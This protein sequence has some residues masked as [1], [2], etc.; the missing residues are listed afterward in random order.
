MSIRQ[1]I[2]GAGIAETSTGDNELFSEEELNDEA[3]ENMVGGSFRMPKSGLVTAAAQQ[4]EEDYDMD[5]ELEHLAKS[6]EALRR[7]LDSICVVA[8]PA[9]TSP[10]LSSASL[11]DE[12]IDEGGNEDDHDS[13]EEDAAD[14]SSIK[15]EETVDHNDRRNDKDNTM[16]FSFILPVGDSIDTLSD[17]EEE[18]KIDASKE[19]TLHHEPEATT[20]HQQHGQVEPWSNDWLTG[21]RDILRS[22][23]S[24]HRV[25]VAEL[26]S[27]LGEFKREM[28]A[29]PP[30]AQDHDNKEEAVT[31]A[32]KSET[33][34]SSSGIDAFS[35]EEEAQNCV[36]SE[37]AQADDGIFEPMKDTFS[38]MFICNIK[39][40]GFA[41]SLF[42]FALQVTI[43]VLIGVNILKN[44]PDGN[45]L[46][47]PVGTSLD[48]VWAQVLALLVS[49][50]TQSDFMA[51]FDLINFKYDDI[52]LSLFEGA[53]HT[54][55]I[56]S[57]IC[58]FTI[59]VLSI[60]ISFILIVQSTT[61]IELFFNFAAV[62][63]VSELDNIAF[64]L[65]YKGYMA[66]GDLEQATRKLINQ[67]Q[68]WQRNMVAF[69]RIKRRIPVKWLRISIF[70][71][72]AVI[73][74]SFWFVVRYKQATGQYLHSICQ[75][76]DVNF[77]DKVSN[78][79]TA[80][81]CFFYNVTDPNNVREL[82]YGPFSGIY[83]VYHDN[84]DNFVW[85]GGRPV[86]YTRNIE[87]GD[88]SH[89]G[90]FSY[91]KNEKAWVFTIDGVRKA[92]SDKCN[93]LLRSPKTEAY[94]LG[95]V[96]TTGWSIW[97]DD[98][99]VPADP[100]FELSC[101]ECESDVDCSYL[102]GS[103]EKKI[104]VCD[105]SWT[106]RN[107]QT[108]FYCSTLHSELSFSNGGVTKTSPNDSKAFLH[109][110]GVAYKER[111]VYYSYMV[112]MPIE[113][114]FYSDGRFNV[115]EWEGFAIN[116]SLGVQDNDLAKLRDYFD[117]VHSVVVDINKV[118]FYVDGYLDVKNTLTFVSELTTAMEPHSGNVKW[119]DDWP[120]NGTTLH[121]SCLSSYLQS[122]CQ[123]FE[124]H[125]DETLWNQ[126]TEDSCTFYN[127]TD[128]TSAALLSYGHFSDIYEVSHDSHGSFEWK[129]RRPIYYQR[130]IEFGEGSHTGKFSYCESEEAWVFTIDT[131]M[132]VESDECNWLLRSP[133]TEAYSL[134]DAPRTGWSTIG[135]NHTLVPADRLFQF[136]C[137]ECQL[138]HNCTVSSG[139]RG[140]PVDVNGIDFS[141]AIGSYLNS[142]NITYGS[143]ISC[144]DVGKVTDM[145]YA[146]MSLTT[147][148][149]PLCWDV[150]RV[151]HMGHMFDVANAFNQN[152]SSWD[153]SSVTSMEGMFAS[154]S[155]FN[156]D[157]S[158]WD[159]SSV[160]VMGYMF[161]TA[162]SF[163]QDLSS[164]NVSNVITMELMFASA[165]A[166][167]QDI[168]SWDVSSVKSMGFMFQFNIAFNQDIA[169]WDVSCVLSMNDM[170]N[171]AS[172]FNQ[173]LCDWAVKTPSLMQVSHMFESTTCPNS[174][175]P[176][177][178]VSPGGTSA[179]P[180]PGPF[181][182]DCAMTECKH[183]HNCT[184]SS[185]N[186][187]VPVNVNGVDFMNV[188][189]SYLNS[190][191]STYGTKISCWDVGKVTDMSFAFAELNDF[192]E[193]LCWGVSSVISMVGMFNEAEA[194]NQDISSWGV[195]SVIN[196]QG[197][198]ATAI[199][200]NQ[201]IS[202][203]DVSRVTDM[204]GMFNEAEAFN[205]DISSW[206]VSSITNME[207]MFNHASTFNQDISS[208]D[209]STVTSMIYMFDNAS[210]FNQDVSSWDVSSVTDMNGMFALATVFNQDLSSWNVSSV[211]DMYFMFYQATAFNQ[212]LCNWA[213]KTPFLSNATRMF[214]LTRC[215]NSAT[216]QFVSPGG[217][218]DIP[219]LGP[220]CHEC[221]VRR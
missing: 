62:Q 221:I 43:L 73:L 139:N 59:G 113:I 79:C 209:V 106:G 160:K 164:W 190:G 56:V 38:L 200:F 129:G 60:G 125:F 133:K 5:D 183:R 177:Q 185:G 123:S 17:D 170:F 12:E 25:Q 93:W 58:R 207:W 66:I 188:I 148:N 41:Y 91:C 4:E 31:G 34:V 26:T 143:K 128:S 72:H 49:L 163:N 138:R 97:T 214:E 96:P 103:C 124:A 176:P 47:V 51:T 136:T 155:A 156:Q 7:E 90:K 180:H 107:C 173:N 16:D 13:I 202:S 55:W 120:A 111:P 147:F 74:Y 3:F 19:N 109:L 212:D 110:K 122:V 137:G 81:S 40:L 174:A 23:F 64:Q 181:C 198:F 14:D 220:F 193:P 182:H 104:C 216:P 86:Y 168:S 175:T 112:N 10:R 92:F 130:N 46:N 153:V 206:D 140:V 52:V 166:F 196:M 45:P 219:H 208:W 63:F 217:T 68:F 161:D 192:N 84:H 115:I 101:A 126:C 89:P 29:A 134:G 35:N 21:N 42:F 48:V 218:P 204:K 151:T 213:V 210:A 118:A 37:N 82:P 9:V 114:L 135:L 6:G 158:S 167:N 33:H 201:N 87:I 146:F 70:S 131:V 15:E 2:T 88:G 199:A 85:K 144:W 71:L 18:A 191:K 108:S 54:K 145:S 157:I 186:Q 11:L 121:L 172:A 105:P 179:N 194:F 76:F 152:V 28:A 83:E 53:T 30:R 142:D 27:L 22:Q 77:G 127:K 116:Q 189:R 99:L 44:A 215:R 171:Y 36:S 203:W 1:R 162:N 95:D 57:N 8:D 61:V 119:R 211:E 178:L 149:E 94:S 141:N 67:V 80:D 187:G 50:I 24:E 197:M 117:K 159:V 184:I 20:C 195:S 102:H 69:P 169:S 39:S 100:H 154:A 75:S 32:R 65:A 78:L 98:A 205:Q 132:K 165:S 150:S